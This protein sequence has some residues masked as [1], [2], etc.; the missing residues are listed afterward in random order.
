MRQAPRGGRGL[1]VPAKPGP[2][3]SFPAASR[4][5]A[6]PA[7]LAAAAPHSPVCLPS[8]GR[9][10]DPTGACVPRPL[11]LWVRRSSPWCARGG[12]RCARL[13]ALQ[14]ERESVPLLSCS[15]HLATQI[16]RRG[17]AGQRRGAR[18]RAELW[19]RTEMGA[20]SPARLLPRMQW[21]RADRPPPSFKGLD[22]EPGGTGNVRDRGRE[23]TFPTRLI[24]SYRSFF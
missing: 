23:L 15:G 12:R 19:R 13:G 18:G 6:D 10:R 5:A 24:H 4:G 7:G 2:P 16:Q 11:S 1:W 3:S 20:W 22:P 8:K 9:R 14:R 17:E 21:E